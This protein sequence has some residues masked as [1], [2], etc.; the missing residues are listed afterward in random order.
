MCAE[1]ISV[2]PFLCH[3]VACEGSF[4]RPL[5]NCGGC[6]DI[7]QTSLRKEPGPPTTPC[8]ACRDNGSWVLH[9]KK[10][11]TRREFKVWNAIEEQVQEANRRVEALMTQ[12]PTGERL[13]SAE[14]AIERVTT[15]FERQAADELRR[16]EE[17]RAKAEAQAADVAKRSFE[18][19]EC[20]A[21][22]RSSG[23]PVRE[24]QNHGI[25]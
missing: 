15:V 13:R 21:S 1:L 19:D 24:M 8:R 17:A 18:D 22:S 23:A 14:E 5:S 12:N 4:T 11:M 25:A 3:H 2:T 16:K 10:W 9:E 6:G 20:A 7:K